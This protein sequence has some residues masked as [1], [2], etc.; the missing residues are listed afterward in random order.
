MTELLP[1]SPSPSCKADH[2]CDRIPCFQARLEAT[3]GHLCV[4]QRAEL[5]ADHLGSTVHALAAWAR[6]EG[7]D[8][9]VTV[10]AID[11]PGP[12]QSSPAWGRSG[13][14]F[15]TIPIHP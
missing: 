2:L 15:A 11:L 14:A 4:R 10:L 6:R 7:L 12:G 5:C 9:E 13:L 8:G 3:A 1:A